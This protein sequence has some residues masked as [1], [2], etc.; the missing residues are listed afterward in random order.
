MESGG[1]KKERGNGW[2][3][4]RPTIKQGGK[5][6]KLRPDDQIAEG[7][8]TDGIGEMGVEHLKEAR[9]GFVA[10]GWRGGGAYQWGH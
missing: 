4:I 10:G 5:V 1:K 6:K 9:K 8:D 3:C 2:D 7:K